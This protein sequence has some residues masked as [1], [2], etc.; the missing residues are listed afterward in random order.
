MQEERRTIE[1]NMAKISRAT[2]KKTKRES[3]E[4]DK[5]RNQLADGVKEHRTRINKTIKLQESA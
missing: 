5:A 3:T 2:R 4:E 1:N